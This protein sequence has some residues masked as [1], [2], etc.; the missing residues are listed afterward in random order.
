MMQAPQAAPDKK[1]YVPLQFR[2]LL[3]K[4]PAL[5]VEERAGGKGADG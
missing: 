3:R 5:R 4:M 1:L 2:H